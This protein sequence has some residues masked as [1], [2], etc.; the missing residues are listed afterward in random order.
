MTAH[1]RARNLGDSANIRRQDGQEKKRNYSRR[2]GARFIKL[3]LG[4]PCLPGTER[5]LQTEYLLSGGAT[6]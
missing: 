3:T 1:E 2:L 5:G 6:A 4:D